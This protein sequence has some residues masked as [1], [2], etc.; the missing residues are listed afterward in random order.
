MTGA[1]E[2]V[3]KQRIARQE[4]MS[5]LENYK[6]DEARIGMI[7]SHSALDL[8][9][10]AEEEGFETVAICERGRDEVYT[11][12]FKEIITK[13][14]FL[15]HFADILSEDKQRELR[16]WYT[17]IVPNRSLTSYVPIEKIETD[18][19]L[20]VFGNRYMLKVDEREAQHELFMD[21]EFD[22]PERY[23]SYK[24]IDKLCMVKA[25]EPKK[26]IER[27]FFTCTSPNEFLKKYEARFGKSSQ[28]SLEDQLNTGE[29]WIEEFIVGAHFNFNYFYSPLKNHTE[30][31]GID[32][33]I[34]TNIDGLLKLPHD[35]DDQYAKNLVAEYVEVGHQSATIRESMLQQVFSLGKKFVESSKRLY[36]PYGIIGPFALQGAVTPD[37][38]IHVFD[39]SPRMPG[40]P[41]L[42]SSPYSKYKFRR[43]VTSGQRV[44]MEIRQAIETKQLD[45]IIT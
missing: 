30:F 40:A 10:G 6:L 36:P 7:A 31:L 23:R 32:R 22:Y 4:V 15:D 37:L 45:K 41:V 14:L 33:R 13:Q 2:Q 21:A 27:A 11:E 17:I 24:D 19:H 8:A 34:Q 1:Y 20:P 12:E 28:N 35:V 29:I 38:K 39:L 3:N 18:L 43:N 42:Y 26:K 44:A 5:I 16:D 25:K 9:D